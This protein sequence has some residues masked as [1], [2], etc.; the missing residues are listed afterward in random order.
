MRGRMS[1]DIPSDGAE[2]VTM[3][4]RRLTRAELDA[5]EGRERTSMRSLDWDA[6]APKPIPQRDW[7]IDHWIGAGHVTLLSGSGGIGKSVLALQ[8][9]TSV[10]RGIHFLAP[11]RRARS[12]L[13]WMAED[14][15]DEIWRRQAAICAKFELTFP[16]LTGGLYVDA[17]GD[18]ECALVQQTMGSSLTRT[19]SLTDLRDRIVATNAELVVLD[20]IARFY[21]G[22][23]NDRHHVTTFMAALNWAAAPTGAAVLLLGHISRGMGSEFSGSSAWENAARARLWFTDK[24]PDKHG[25]DDE[26]PANDLR[27][28]AKRKANYTSRDLCVMRYSDGAYDILSPPSGG[29]GIVNAIDRANASKAVMSA[30]RALIGLNFVSSDAPT[31]HQYLPKLIMQHQL[32]SGHTKRDLADAM[33]RL[34]A[35]GD[36]VREHVK[37]GNRSTTRIELRPRSNDCARA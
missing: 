26:E 28:L 37:T 27:Y 24:P 11:V 15:H 32:A 20:N 21:G 13:V 22:N 7:I 1:E 25:D 17:M 30:L 16:E 8:L 2:V 9:A 12:C 18:A 10:A 35:D 14:D 19:G 31:S 4:E 23:E 36:I 6:L 29:S 33:H 3:S 34:V 5:R